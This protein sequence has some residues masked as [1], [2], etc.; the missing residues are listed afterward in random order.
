MVVTVSLQKG[1]LLYILGVVHREEGVG[2][3]VYSW[4]SRI[5]PAAVTIEFSRYGLTFRKEYGP[6]FR[7][8]TESVVQRMMDEGVDVDKDILSSLLAVVEQPGEYQGALRYSGEMRAP[9]YLIDMDYF[10]AARLRK[11][12]ELFSEENLRVA[13]LESGTGKKGM[14]R[15]LARLSLRSGLKITDYTDEMLIRDRYMSHRIAVLMKYHR[16]GT[17]VHITGWRHLADPYGVFE[18]FHPIKVFPYD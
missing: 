10:S 5:S 8:R 12:T 7:E 18:Q 1:S 11:M 16:G 3:L 17:I 6:L 14:E 2:D 4:L 13:L 9:L 15:A